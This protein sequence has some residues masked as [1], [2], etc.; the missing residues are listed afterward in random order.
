MAGPG[1]SAFAPAV[2]ALGV[3]AWFLT[4]VSCQAYAGR[5]RKEP[6]STHG[7]D[8]GSF[9]VVA[10]SLAVGTIAIFAS[11][12]KAA[13]IPL[14]PWLLLPGVVVLAVGLYVRGWALISLGEFFSV[15]VRTSADQRL[16]RVGPYRRV[17]HPSYT[18]NILIVLGFALIVP[19]AVGLAV[20]L[21]SVFVGHLYRVRIE[22]RALRE[23]FPT[24]YPQYAD[25]SWRLFPGI[26]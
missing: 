24:E 13:A 11:Y 10:G 5:G 17:R 14:T 20:G 9:F 26:Y 1:I 12:G 8:H 25:Y 2:A 3:L 18:G 6:I 21:L 23:R 19:T 15:V 7:Q 22:E 4:E 16:I